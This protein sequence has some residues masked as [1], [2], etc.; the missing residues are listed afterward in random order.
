MAKPRVADPGPDPKQRPGVL[1]EA[2]ELARSKP[3][4]WI[5]ARTYDSPNGAYTT[6]TKLRQRFEDIETTARGRQLFVRV[7]D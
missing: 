3:G 7:A 6:G 2:V 5:L 4:E 1:M